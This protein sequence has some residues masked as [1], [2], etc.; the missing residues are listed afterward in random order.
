MKKLLAIFTFILFSLS[1]YSQKDVT[2][3]LGIPVDGSKKEMIK[4][5]KKKGFKKSKDEKDVLNG[6]FNGQRMNLTMVETN[7]KISRIIVYPMRA[8]SANEAK[9]HFNMLCRQFTNK[10]NYIALKLGKIFDITYEDISIPLDEDI[11]YEIKKNNKEYIAAFIQLPAHK[12]SLLKEIEPLEHISWIVTGKDG[13]KIDVFAN[14]KL[15]LDYSH[16][17]VW[18]TIL[19]YF[20]KYY[21]ALYYD[22][23][24]NRADGED[25]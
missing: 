13:E 9:S 14:N 4:A 10:K 16:N 5:L 2:K 15:Y 3:F 6:E 25:L 19:E 20:G 22:N 24:L 11:D 21:V 18:F 8:G 12:D 7:N 1:T 23:D 17:S